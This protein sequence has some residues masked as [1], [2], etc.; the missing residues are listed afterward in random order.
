MSSASSFIQL[1][2]YVIFVIWKKKKIEKLEKTLHMQTTF[3]D[4][5]WRVQDNLG[6]NSSTNSNLKQRYFSWNL[7]GS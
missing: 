4:G 2:V 6:K 3:D 1:Y 5:L 7:K